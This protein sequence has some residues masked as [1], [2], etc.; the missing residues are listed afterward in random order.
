M[1]YM[2]VIPTN[3]LNLAY[4]RYV[5]ASKKQE[6]GPDWDITAIS[7]QYVL[8]HFTEVALY[9][10]HCSVHVYEWAQSVSTDPLGQIQRKKVESMEC[11][12][13]HQQYKSSSGKQP[14]YWKQTYAREI[15]PHRKSCISLKWVVLYGHF[16]GQ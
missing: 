2:H 9:R 14:G 11:N 3:D 10:L 8:W 12:S 5:S 4:A 6:G 15:L 1:H 7:K 16:M 13:V